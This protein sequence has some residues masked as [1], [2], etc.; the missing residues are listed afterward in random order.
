M[1]IFTLPCCYIYDVFNAVFQRNQMGYINQLAINSKAWLILMASA[2][3]LELVALYFQYIMSLAPCIMCVYQRLAIVSIIL[4]GL[5]GYAFNQYMI[6]RLLAFALW[7]IGSVWGL[8]IAL[9]HVDMQGATLSFFYSCD[10][11]PNFPQWAPLHQWI[12]FLFEAT[13]DCGDINWQFLG[14]SMPQWMTVVY[15]VYSALFIIVLGSR[16][17]NLK[18]V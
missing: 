5:I 6:A 17:I 7:G 1:S 4:A 13:G 11:I 2:L 10:V 14:Y 8:V 15:A 12:P 9:E 18:K 3:S 16:I